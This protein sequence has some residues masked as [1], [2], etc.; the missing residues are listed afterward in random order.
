M[1]RKLRRL[2]LV[3]AVA[4]AAGAVASPAAAWRVVHRPHRVIVVGPRQPLHRTVLVAGRP[5][6]L[7]DFNVTPKATRIWVDGTFRGTCDEFDGHPQKMTLRP[8]T[9]HIRLVN[10]DGIEVERS[11][12]VA[13][14]YEVNLNLEL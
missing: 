14:G 10:P 1:T 4:V 9:H 11:V 13:A 2:A 3:A 6:A 12:T 7:I 5:A 8:G